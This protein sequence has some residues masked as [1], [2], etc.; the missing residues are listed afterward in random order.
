MVAGRP[1]GHCHCTD[2]N[3]VDIK[4]YLDINKHQHWQCTQNIVTSWQEERLGKKLLQTMRTFIAS[5]VGW[6]PSLVGGKPLLVYG[7]V[8]TIFTSFYT[9]FWIWATHHS[10][11]PSLKYFE[12]EPSRAMAANLLAMASNPIGMANI[13]FT[14]SLRLLQSRLIVALLLLRSSKARSY[15]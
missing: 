10:T 11:D 2:N 3:L 8:T 4:T 9:F 12:K 5:L 14:L 7:W 15:Y 1:K 6:R 13:L